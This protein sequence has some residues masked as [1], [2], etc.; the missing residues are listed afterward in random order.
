MLMGIRFD[1]TT[2][3]KGQTL[4]I[5]VLD[6]IMCDILGL[7]IQMIIKLCSPFNYYYYYVFICKTKIS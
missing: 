7:S 1:R 2:R 4:D 6:V 3:R 5:K